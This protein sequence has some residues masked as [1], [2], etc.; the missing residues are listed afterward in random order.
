MPAQRRCLGF[1]LIIALAILPASPA[2][3]GLE[4]LQAVR[5]TIHQWAV[6]WRHH[7]LAGYLSHYSPEFRPKA[8]GR[9]EWLAHKKA[10]FASK[11]PIEV[12]IEGLSVMLDGNRAIARF[13][14]IYQGPGLHDTGIKT[15]EL[16]EN[17]HRWQIVFE[18]WRPAP[19]L[20]PDEAAGEKTAAPPR[21]Q[22]APAATPPV[23]AMPEGGP[24]PALPVQGL[25]FFSAP[26]SERVCVRLNRF[27]I[28]S[29]F[30]L[31]G[32]RPR[33]V[34]DISGQSAWHGPRSLAADGRWIRRVRAFLHEDQRRLRIVL[35]LAPKSDLAVDQHMI[36]KT[37]TFCLELSPT[38]PEA[39]PSK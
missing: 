31:D 9:K 33:L 34:I 15:L 20:T 36:Q 14:Q 7:D 25:R 29:V 39:N 28:P 17:D 13:I 12:R 21:P 24:N 1:F 8:M 35:D 11:E 30:S 22:P 3:A 6:D 4:R 38:T 16:E 26:G 27:F 18:Q 5:D 37:D 32:A 10:V 2:R 19:A 23:P